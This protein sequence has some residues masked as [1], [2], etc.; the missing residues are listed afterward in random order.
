MKPLCAGELV[1]VI[2]EKQRHYAVTLKAGDR[3]Q[4][5]GEWLA[6]D[7]L[8][9]QP[10]GRW[11]KSSGGR[12][13]LVVRPT[14]AE[15]LLRMPRGAQILYPKD[16]AA[17][18]MKADIF[19]GARVLEAGLGSGALTIA[20]L[21]AVGEKGQLFSYEMREDFA[22]RAEKNIQRFLGETPQLTVR[23]RDLAEGIE[24]RELDRVVLDLPEPWRMIT[25]VLEA[26]RPG[27]ILLTFLP[28]VPQVE[29]LVAALQA[30][31]E[32]ALIETT[33][34]LERPW[35]IEGRSVRPQLRMVAHSGFLTVAR[36]VS[37]SPESAAGRPA[38]SAQEEMDDERDA[39]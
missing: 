13:F 18:L 1:H 31:C 14:L 6:H 39:N 17:I 20:L 32:F 35:Q 21:R 30:S 4:Y 29:K 37:R 11:V 36:R 12:W 26:L 24:E 10:E 38:V 9:G 2:S 27:G 22:A 7:E 33:E 28:T 19:P 34:G 16:I 25:G 23:R 8:I 15:Y 3:F 5:S